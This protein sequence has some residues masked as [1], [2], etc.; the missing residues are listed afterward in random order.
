MMNAEDRALRVDGKRLWSRLMEI[1]RIGALPH[2]GVDRQALTDADRRGRDLFR[3]WCEDAGLTVEVDR[4]GNLFAR[5]AGIDDTLPP[6]LVGSHLDSQPTGGKFDGVYGVLAG[7]EVAQTLNERGVRTLHPL[8]IASWTNEEG[9]R[10]SPAMVGSG[11]FAG[12]FTLDYGLSRTDKAGRTLGDELARIGYAGERDVGGHAYAAALELHIEQGPI[13]EQRGLTIGVVTGVQGMRWYDLVIEGREVHAGPT[14]MADR[15]DPFRALCEIQQALYALV[16][17]HAPDSR[18]TFGDLSVEPGSRNTVPGRVVL[19]VDL[20]HPDE[21]TLQ[22][23]EDAFVTIAADA[24]ERHRVTHRI[25][26][27][28]HSPAVR[29]APSCVDAVER[30]SGAL[31]LPACRMVSG[32]GHDSVYLSRMMPTGMIFIPCRDGVSHNEAEE[33]EPAHVEAGANVLLGAIV[34]LTRARI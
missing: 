13:L 32:A 9:A 24:C 25:D 20:R 3:R 21:A 27:V 4:I 23:M 26:T 17:G 16:D 12:V 2:G 5:R 28:W 18:V 29:F 34:E 11:V 7:L 30:A 33:A 22:R 6:V 31:G 15:R 14:P 1:A 19:S 10:F 8:E